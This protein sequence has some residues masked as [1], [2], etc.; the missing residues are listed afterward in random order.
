MP[1]SCEPSNVLRS[2][3]EMSRVR[4]HARI[5]QPS[6]ITTRCPRISATPATHIEVETETFLLRRP[7]EEDKKRLMPTFMPL[8]GIGP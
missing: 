8:G 2:T 6:L 7:G 1:Q 4:I 3:S 5:V